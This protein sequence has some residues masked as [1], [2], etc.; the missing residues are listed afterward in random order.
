LPRVVMMVARSASRSRRAV[1][2][3]SSSAKTRGHSANERFVVMATAR[4]RS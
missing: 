1:V 3:F 4:P 2:S